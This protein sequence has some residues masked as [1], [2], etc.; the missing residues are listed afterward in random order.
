ML[1]IHRRG[2]SYIQIICY[3][4]CNIM[5]EAYLIMDLIWPEDHFQFSPM[6]SELP[7]ANFT[8]ILPDLRSVLSSLVIMQSSRNRSDLFIG[9][10]CSACH[11]L[12]HWNGRQNLKLKLIYAE[13]HYYYYCI[14]L[15][16]FDNWELTYFP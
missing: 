7:Q 4:I 15:F 1:P 12:P 11:F 8:H 13:L 9:E 3:I 10:N 16:S 14:L 2:K 5:Q 6:F